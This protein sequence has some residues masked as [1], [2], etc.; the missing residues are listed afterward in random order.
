VAKQADAADL[1]FERAQPEFAADDKTSQ[2]DD[3]RSPEITPE[4]MAEWQSS[5]N[6]T[7]LAELQAAISNLTRL[8]AKTEDP[9][10]AAELVGERR[11]MRAEGHALWRRSRGR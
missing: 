1:G 7:R 11:A 9:A 5:G 8:L 10:V 4:Q 6:Q 3:P 2:I